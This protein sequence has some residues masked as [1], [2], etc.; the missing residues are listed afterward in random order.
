MLFIPDGNYMIIQRFVR[1]SGNRNTERNKHFWNWIKRWFRCFE[2][3][4]TWAPRRFHFQISSNRIWDAF[5]LLTCQFTDNGAIKPSERRKDPLRPQ[6]PKAP[7]KHI[8][9][10]T[11]NL[12]Y[13]NRN[14]IVLIMVFK[15]VL[16]SSARHEKHVAVLRHENNCW[17]VGW[18]LT[19][20]KL[21]QHQ[22]FH[23]FPVPFPVFIGKLIG[24]GS[25]LPPLPQGLVGVVTDRRWMLGDREADEEKWCHG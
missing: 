10:H 5:K 24:P 1:L 2:R 4:V 9:T 23:L 22:V 21:L 17:I 6:A 14:G 15:S 12:H 11:Y 7:H 13:W 25:F 18:C 16:V 20:R 8:N 3:R 19:L